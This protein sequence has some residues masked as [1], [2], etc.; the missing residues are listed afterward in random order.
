MR[1]S[2]C[3]VS[4]FS[5]L[6]IVLASPIAAQANR[7]PK[8]SKSSVRVSEKQT[9]NIQAELKSLTAHEWAGEY[10]YGDGLG[11]NVSLVLAPAA[12]FVFRW[13]GC[14]GLYDLNYGRVT[15]RNGIITLQ[16]TYPNER[17]GFQGIATELV[18]VRWGERHYLVPSDGIVKFANAV[19]AGTEPN[20]FMGGRSFYFLLKRGDEG[21]AVHGTPPIPQEY[22]PYLLKSPIHATIS[23]IDET[24]REATARVTK[25]MLDSGRA[26]GLLKGMELYVHE[27]G[28]VE[29]ATI[30]QVGDHSSQAV[31]YQY[32]GTAIAPAPG[33]KLSTK[34]MDGGPVGAGPGS[35]PAD[36]ER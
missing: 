7:P 6:W 22:S 33:W 21:K 17:E 32:D 18:P 2:V 36:P 19:N 35:A 3:V 13:D 24:H 30:M 28:K 25:V 1:K 34:L 8:L 9:K 14:L 31:I 10:Y 16:F 11:V 5:L 26:Q 15:E 20:D 29:T 4:L 27:S 23:A 12:G